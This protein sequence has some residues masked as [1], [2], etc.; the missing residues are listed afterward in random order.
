MYPYRR[1]R[2]DLAAE[3]AVSHGAAYVRPSA[4]AV[5]GSGLPS[6]IACCTQSN[7]ACVVSGLSRIATTCLTVFG[8]ARQVR[9]KLSTFVCPIVLPRRDSIASGANC[10]WNTT[11]TSG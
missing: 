2:S 9:R 7:V 11:L 3:T 1:E 5:P 10:D 4:H 6:V 8:S